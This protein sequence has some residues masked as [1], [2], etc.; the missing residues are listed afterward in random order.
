MYTCD[1]KY[2]E[3]SLLSYLDKT[4]IIYKYLIYV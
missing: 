2:F 1:I 4:D 3:I